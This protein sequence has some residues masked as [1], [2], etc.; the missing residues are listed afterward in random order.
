MAK[1]SLKSVLVQTNAIFCSKYKKKTCKNLNLRKAVYLTLKKM[2]SNA[3]CKIVVPDKLT[4]FIYFLCTWKTNT[5]QCYTIER[6]NL[7]IGLCFNF[8]CSSY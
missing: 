7:T 4:S 5:L 8:N 2:A 1:S 3:M 6:S